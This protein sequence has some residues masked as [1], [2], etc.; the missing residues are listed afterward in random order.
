MVV[1]I[2]VALVALAAPARADGALV[3]HGGG[4]LTREV[5]QRFVDLAGGADGHLVV[6]PTASRDP[7]DTDGLVAAW[8]AWGFASVVVLHAGTRAQADDPD[9][10]AALTTATAVWFDG[11][12][13]SRLERAYRGTLVETE[14]HRLIAR[15]GVIGGSSAGAAIMSRVM[16]RGG[17][18]RP[19]MGIGFDLLPDAII[20]QHFIARARK[21]R[22]LIA[23]AHH[24]TLVGY[25]ID[26][27]TA[28]VVQGANLE[29]V[30]DSTVTVAMAATRTAPPKLLELNAGSTASATDLADEARAR[31]R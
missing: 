24:R 27:G 30:G 17:K 16:I 9:F 2:L 23:L 8:S 10:V 29:V 3:I 12:E 18:T 14:L 22:L 5:Q 28:L 4:R 6:I 25:G 31:T 26:E 19:R 1:G 20:D 13:Q 7:S 11:G 15:G 21:H